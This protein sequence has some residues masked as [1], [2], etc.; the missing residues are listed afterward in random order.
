V[1]DSSP[2]SHQ[3]ATFDK[4]VQEFCQPAAFVSELP[5]KLDL[6]GL[7]EIFM[8]KKYDLCGGIV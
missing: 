5:Y 6:L 3:S 2:A 1:T 4:E 7:Y 8:N